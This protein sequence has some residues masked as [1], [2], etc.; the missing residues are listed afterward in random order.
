MLLAGGISPQNPDP[1]WGR[2]G[3]SSAAPLCSSTGKSSGLHS[4]TG[5]GAKINAHYLLYAPLIPS[6]S[7]SNG[8]VPKKTTSFLS[9]EKHYLKKLCL[10]IISE[11]LAKK[12]K[13]VLIFL[14]PRWKGEKITCLNSILCCPLELRQGIISAQQRN[15]PSKTR[16]DTRR[17]HPTP[18]FTNT[19]ALS[20][21]MVISL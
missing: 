21:T 19:S 10:A 3:V 16:V 11:F 17:H 7:L 9:R 8:W 6:I 18:H 15:S 12:K 13:R 2:R 5:D 4:A 14:I 1:E 20:A